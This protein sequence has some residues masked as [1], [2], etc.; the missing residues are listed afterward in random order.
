LK[1]NLYSD[2]IDQDIYENIFLMEK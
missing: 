1:T 2:I